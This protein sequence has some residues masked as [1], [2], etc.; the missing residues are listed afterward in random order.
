VLYNPLFC[1][2]TEDGVRKRAV[3]AIAVRKWP[4]WSFLRPEDSE[5]VA[6]QVRAT[7]NGRIFRASEE[8]IEL[9]YGIVEEYYAAARVVVREDGERFKRQYFADGAGVWLAEIDELVMGCVALRSLDGMAGAAEIKRMYVRPEY[10]G[11]GVSDLLL[12][13]LEKYASEFG[14]KW[15]YLDTAVDMKAAARFY[16]RK[17]FVACKRYNQNPQAAIFMKKRIG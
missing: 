7:L 12:E 4:I 8:Q 6:F 16:E 9:A 10:R 1:H 14:Y 2:R 3:R 15:L 5:M 17:G 13:A 11:Q